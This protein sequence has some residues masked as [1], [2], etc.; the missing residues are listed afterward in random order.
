MP[1]SMSRDEITKF[2]LGP[3]IARLATVQPGGAPYIAPVWQQWDGERM[4]IVG[5]AGSEFVDHIR[6]ESRVAVSC[7]D[8]V[9]TEHARVLIEGTAEVLEGPAPMTGRMLQIAEE[10][11]VRYMGPNGPT[12]M[13]NTA[14][15]PRCLIAVMPDSIVSWDGGD[16]H[17]RYTR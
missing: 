13:K 9:N 10:M 1:G 14:D 7:A 6:N 17:P 11:A 3:V 4:Y 16:W 5:R 8:D 2:L 12:Y 15:R